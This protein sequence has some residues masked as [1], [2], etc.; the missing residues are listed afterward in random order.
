[1]YNLNLVMIE[2]ISFLKVICIN[3]GYSDNSIMKFLIL[4]TW[5]LIKMYFK[6]DFC[7]GKKPRKFRL[8]VHF[9]NNLEGYFFL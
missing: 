1:M 9:S 8:K 7:F 6:Y 3:L 4:G 2:R 5:N